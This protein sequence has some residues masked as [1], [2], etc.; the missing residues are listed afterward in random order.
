M[1]AVPTRLTRTAVCALLIAAA[2]LATAARAGGPAA[3]PAGAASPRRIV[4]LIPATTEMLFAMGAA[5][6]LAG[7]GAYDRFPPEVDR[8]PRVGG[9]LDPN[10]E[11]ILSLEPDLVIVYRTQDTLRRQLDRAG[12]PTFVY[13]HRDLADIVR[14]MRAIGA[15]IGAAAAADAAAGRIERQL[16]DVRARVKGRRR[17]GTLLV[18]GREPGSL[19]RID[20]SG[21]YGFLHDVLEVAGGSNVL[22]DFMRQSVQTSTELILARAPDVIVELRYGDAQRR[23]RLDAELRVWD[24]LASVPAVKGRRIHLLVG[25]EFVVPGPR[26]GLAAER[27]ARALHPDTFQ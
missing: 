25:D 17:P 14:T 5:D 8:L 9:V 22:G 16:D 21:G 19:R 7:V 12:I 10:V 27:F 4:S 1:A 26:I 20:A 24:A 13:E 23:E 15:R 3:Q 6:R 11:R 2:L 18:F